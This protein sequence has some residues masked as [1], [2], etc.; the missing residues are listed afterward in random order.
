MLVAHVEQEGVW[1]VEGGMHRLAQAL[2]G[3]AERCGATFRY[4]A[5][6]AEVLVTGGR[7]AGVRL[8]S[9]DQLAADAIVT[10]ADVG[11][12]AAGLFGRA[13]AGAVPTVPRTARSLS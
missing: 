4:G 5:E 9:G 13:A 3:L 1:L 10:N 2:A 8:A 11:A 12:L 6:A 7:V